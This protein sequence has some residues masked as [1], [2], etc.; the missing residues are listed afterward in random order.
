MEDKNFNILEE[1]CLSLK[2]SFKNFHSTVR[3][4]IIY[5]T[6]KRDDNVKFSA[7]YPEE[8]KEKIDELFNHNGKV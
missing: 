3:K 2:K 1:Y 8:I 4:G 5:L 6:D 7:Y